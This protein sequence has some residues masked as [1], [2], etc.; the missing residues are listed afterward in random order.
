MTGA[1]ECREPAGLLLRA[2]VAR[3]ACGAA[4]VQS[5]VACAR[6]RCTRPMRTCSADRAA[7]A[8]RHQVFQHGGP[9]DACEGPVCALLPTEVGCYAPPQLNLVAVIGRRVLACCAR[10]LRGGAR[11]HQQWRRSCRRRHLRQLPLRCRI[12]TRLRRQPRAHKGLPCGGA[13]VVRLL[14]ACQVGHKRRSRGARQIGC[15]GPS[16]R[17]PAQR[18]DAWGARSVHGSSYCK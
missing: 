4:T 16:R 8:R 11:R 6:A 18:F 17:A 3:A 12:P 7:A 2:E 5:R 13:D 15:A 9:V 10:H 1:S 14:V